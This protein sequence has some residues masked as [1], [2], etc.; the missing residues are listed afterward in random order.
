SIN[1]VIS[2]V[3]LNLVNADPGVSYTVGVER[4]LEAVEASV[5]KFADTFNEL[6][7]SI[8]SLRN[9]QLEA[10]SSLLSIERQVFAVLNTP[11][12]GGVY[13]VLSEVG[14]SMQKDGTMSLKSSD[15]SAALQSDFNGVAQLFAADGQGFA[16]RLTT[17]ADTWLTTGGLIES[18]TDGLNSRI[19]DLLNRQ[20]AFERRLITTEERFRAQFSALDSLVGQLQSTGNFLTQQLAQLPGANQG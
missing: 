16:N 9:G 17:L 3:T 15:L 12:A 4:D 2:G 18:R 14:L 11:A 8:K 10:D 5:Q 19:D 6:R 1:D 20:D 7:S 13:S